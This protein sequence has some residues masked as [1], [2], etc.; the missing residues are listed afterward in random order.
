MYW[1]FREGRRSAGSG[2]VAASRRARATGAAPLA[3]GSSN[4]ERRGPAQSAGAPARAGLISPPDPRRPIS[5]S[6]RAG[7]AS[8]R[9]A[10]MPMIV[11]SMRMADGGMAFLVTGSCGTDMVSKA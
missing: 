11:R 2:D 6:A 3:A 4:P 10:A 8:A 9:N 7:A 5:P 1:T